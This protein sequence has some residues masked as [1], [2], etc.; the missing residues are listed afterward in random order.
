MLQIL[1]DQNFGNQ[2]QQQ[3]QDIV[4]LKNPDQMINYNIENSGHLTTFA[5]KADWEHV[6]NVIPSN[7]TATAILNLTT[8]W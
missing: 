5:K 4:S 1:I 6:N 3:Q 7:P 2:S 8:L